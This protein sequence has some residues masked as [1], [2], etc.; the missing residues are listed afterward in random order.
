[1]RKLEDNLKSLGF[2]SLETEIY[3]ALLGT[4]PM[5]AYQLAKKINIARPSIYQALEHML[6]KGMVAQVPEKTPLYVP[7]RPEILLGKLKMQMTDSLEESGKQLQEYE[8]NRRV[9][10]YLVFRGYETAIC[11]AK[12]FLKNAE[13]E[14]Y[15]NA[16]F[17]LD[18]FSEE[19]SKL[20]NRGVRI[21]VFSFYDVL[22]EEKVEVFSHHR[23]LKGH[24]PS[25][26]MLVVDDKIALTA[27]GSGSEQE[28][29]GTVSSNSLT[30]R[31]LTE[32]IHHD[33]YLLKLRERYGKEIY[34]EDIKL[35]TM[36]EQQ[37]KEEMA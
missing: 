23:S 17:Q 3:L 36:F 21:L 16:D 2:S 6:S 5:S 15:V 28:W 29:T 27:D 35:H 31:I 1:M 30:V 9:E 34:D 10:T 25:R 19:F 20:R 12:E 8:Q 18:I 13:K 22:K 14:V 24:M 33:I 32:H 4:E 26:L 11:K 37:K 7:E